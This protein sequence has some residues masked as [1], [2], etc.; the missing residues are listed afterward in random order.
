MNKPQDATNEH[1]YL[2]LQVQASYYYEFWASQYP[3][4]THPTFT[5]QNLGQFNVSSTP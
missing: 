5:I 4:P 1:P 3:L 2:T